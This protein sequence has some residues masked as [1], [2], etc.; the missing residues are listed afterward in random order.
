[1]DDMKLFVKSGKILNLL[2]QTVK[3]M[4]DNAG[5]MFGIEQYVVL[6]IKGG[7]YFMAEQ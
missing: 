3:V 1:M 7:K 5:L 6:E 4:D 2:V